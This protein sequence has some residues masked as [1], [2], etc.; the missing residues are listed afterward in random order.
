[1]EGNGNP[2]RKDNGSGQAW[3]E[4]L[5][6]RFDP[7]TFSMHIDGHVSNSDM[8]LAMLEQAKREYEA[9]DRIARLARVQAQLA[10]KAETQRIANSLRRTV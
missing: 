4:E 6:I 10:D 9:Q 5:I 1:M 3:P 8:A 2:T 7:M